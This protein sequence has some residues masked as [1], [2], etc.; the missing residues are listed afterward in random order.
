MPSLKRHEGYL[1]MDNRAAPVPDEVLRAAGLPAEAGRGLY[2]C[3]V[4]TCSHC[5]VQVI[6]NPLRTRERAYCRKCDHYI[7][8]NCGAAYGAS[9]GE[10]KPFRKIIDEVQEQA[11][12]NEQ[13]AQRGIILLPPE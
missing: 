4:I 8:D 5:Q 12:L 13:R 2:E 3:G 9:G 10:C 1:M 6:V 11:A 7:C